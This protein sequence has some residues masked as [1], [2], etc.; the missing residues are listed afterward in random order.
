M[1]HNQNLESTLTTSGG[2]RHSKLVSQLNHRHLYCSNM[3]STSRILALHPDSVV[4]KTAESCICL[5]IHLLHPEQQEPQ[6][7]IPSRLLA[8]GAS[9]ELHRA[10]MH[11]MI[12]TVSRTLKLHPAEQIQRHVGSQKHYLRTACGLT[13]VSN[14][15][16][17][18][19]SWPF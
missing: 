16:I 9:M 8:S 4:R 19:R 18:A 1:A 12:V 17:E 2:T 7:V 13:L 6:S 11:E 5:R 15:V 3:E 14:T 10:I